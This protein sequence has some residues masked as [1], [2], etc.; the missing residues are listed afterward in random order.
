MDNIGTSVQCILLT[1]SLPL[2]TPLVPKVIGKVKLD[3]IL[4]TG[5]DISIISERLYNRFA[6]VVELQ[7]GE[8]FPLSGVSGRKLATLGHISTTILIGKLKLPMKFQVVR[9]ITKDALLGSDFLSMTKGKVDYESRT[10]EIY[11]K[12]VILQMKHNCK[13]SCSLVHVHKRVKLD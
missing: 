6:K 11:D 10:L 4:D 3:A 8:S 1:H 2:Y 7:G 5:A 9:G 12:V 13:T